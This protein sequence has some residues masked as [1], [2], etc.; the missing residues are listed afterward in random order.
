[1]RTQAK[2][3]KRAKL[4]QHGGSQALRLP[5]EFRFKGRDVIVRRDPWTNDVVL[6]DPRQSWR[7]FFSLRERLGGNEDF[8]TER[9]DDI[10]QS[11]KLFEED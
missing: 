8:L 2:Q 6:S 5:A 7:D 11:R 10:P 1:M 3:P 4:F 9:M